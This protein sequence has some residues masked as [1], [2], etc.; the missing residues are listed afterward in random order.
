MQSGPSRMVN[1]VSQQRRLR[2]DKVFSGSLSSSN[3]T[4]KYIIAAGYFAD[5]FC[6]W[7]LPPKGQGLLHSIQLLEV[8]PQLKPACL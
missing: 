2:L 1:T 8:L 6:C 5:N 7:A 4:V 3:F